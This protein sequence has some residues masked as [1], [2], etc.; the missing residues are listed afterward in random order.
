MASGTYEYK[1]LKGLTI[2]LR[3][4]VGLSFLIGLG[5]TIAYLMVY[6]N[7]NQNP[8]T[9]QKV[10]DMLT[11]PGIFDILQFVAVI[12]YVVLFLIW[13]H[14]GFANLR[15]TGS[16]D[17]TKPWKAVLFCIIPIANLYLPFRLV[18]DLWAASKRSAEN[19]VSPLINLWWWT[20][21]LS[22]FVSKIGQRN[23][24]MLDNDS[25]NKTILTTPWDSAHFH[26]EVTLGLLGSAASEVLFLLSLVAFFFL[27]QKISQAQEALPETSQSI[28]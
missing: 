22:A 27:S 10:L 7:F 2:A 15:A 20:W 26:T 12:V 24:Q 3:V 11:L 13:L 23:L 19:A 28:Q 4:T 8:M 25:A 18:S 6:A 14:R 5:D 9:A 17:S 1:P 21:L 16:K